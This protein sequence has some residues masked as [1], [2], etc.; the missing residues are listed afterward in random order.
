MQPAFYVPSYTKSFGDSPVNRDSQG[1]FCPVFA[2][3]IGR[4]GLTIALMMDVFLTF[5]DYDLVVIKKKYRENLLNKSYTFC[6]QTC[7]FTKYFV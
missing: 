1:Q 2:S 3:H 5:Y 6:D 4:L 7:H